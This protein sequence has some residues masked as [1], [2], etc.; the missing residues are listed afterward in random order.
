MA[1]KQ[2]QIVKFSLLIILAVIVTKC[3][4]QMSP[5]GGDIDKTPPIV[6]YNYPEN[7]TTNFDENTI[8]F[9]FSEYVNKRKITEA[10]FVSPLMERLPEFSWTNKTVTVEFTD[11][12][13][14][15]TT[16]SVFIGTEIT[17]MNNNNK[18]A[19]P[20]VL[21]FS[22]GSKIDSGKISGKVNTEKA[23]GTLIFAYKNL[24]TGAVDISNQ[25]PN[26][27]SQISDKGLYQ[28]SGLG[29][30]S[31]SIFAVKD[32]FKDLLYNVGDDLIGIP[33][34]SVV[35][36]KQD[37]KIINLDFLLM[38]EDTLAP[39]VQTITMTD[40]NHI[41]VEFSEPIDSSILSVTNFTL[42]DSTSNSNFDLKYW[43]KTKSNKN[44]YVLCLSDSL[45][46]ENE[47]YLHTN[48]IA[49]KKGN[50][51]LSELTSFIASDK[52]DTNIISIENVITPFDKSTID[53]V[54]PSFSLK[55]SDGFDISNTN[56]GIIFLNLD[57]LEIPFKYEKTS[58][59]QVKIIP[60]SNLE[61]ETQYKIYFEMKYFEDAAGNVKDTLLAK[62]ISTISDLAFSGASGKVKSNRD[63]VKVVLQEIRSSKRI[64]TSIDEKAEFIFERVLPGNYLVWAFEDDDSS[65]N[66][67]YGNVNPIEYSEYFK[68]Y[69]DTLNLRPRWPVGDI[70][71][72]LTNN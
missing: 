72:D 20:F 3:A 56:N 35:L 39:N 7:G 49:D 26:Y 15:N 27:L 44:E 34:K 37:K 19:E 68:F 51:L 32:A 67:S 33:A 17:D 60:G 55:F 69:S 28:L 16:Y 71:I 62:R 1:K 31:Y 36:T 66:Y 13:Q 54:S 5:P 11:T 61:E 22:T 40:R 9:G 42:V 2:Q 63:N 14:K 52:A 4:N 43:F 53:Y 6:I 30:G 8:E 64:I 57:S 23:D 24:D 41:I 59:A 50:I 10:F 45:N 25:K 29:E 18:M 46:I 47:F 21:T 58:D 38:Q 70:E 12:L 65:G 48:N